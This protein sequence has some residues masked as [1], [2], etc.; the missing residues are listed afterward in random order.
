MG[1][2]KQVQDARFDSHL[3]GVKK[4]SFHW[5]TKTIHHIT[6]GFPESENKFTMLKK[7]IRSKLI[8]GD[9]GADSGGKGKTKRAEKNGA[10]K[11]K[12]R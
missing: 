11:S 10:K 5:L 4:E 7:Y 3:T 12:E 1:D 9:P 8:L 6:K 2:R